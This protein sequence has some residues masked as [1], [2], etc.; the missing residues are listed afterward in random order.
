MRSPHRQTVQTPGATPRAHLFRRRLIGLLKAL[1]TGPNSGD[2]SR[3]IILAR[4][5]R[6][7][8]RWSSTSDQPARL[9]NRRHP[10]SVGKGELPGR[11]RIWRRHRRQAT[12]R[13]REPPSSLNS[14]SAGLRQA[15]N[16]QLRAG[17][18]GAA[19]VGERGHGIVEEHD[20]EARDHGVV[21]SLLRPRTCASPSTKLA[22]A[23][24]PRAAR[25]A[26]SHQRMRDVE[27]TQLA[28]SRRRGAPSPASWRRSP[29]PMSRTWPPSPG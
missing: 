4:L 13:P 26:A 24:P 19:D 9:Q 8:A 21:P 17:P 3:Q 12:G 28:A 23:I 6:H 29:Q 5:A 11:F 16:A 2:V 20:A 22:F 15:T 25:F 1:P 27:P 18:R 7:V 14:F 10:R